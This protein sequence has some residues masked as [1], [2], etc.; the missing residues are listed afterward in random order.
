MTSDCSDIIRKHDPDRFLLSLFVPRA[1]RA[2]LWALFAFNYEIA[3]TREV[4]SDT[5]IGLIRLQWWRD[6]IAEIYAE[7]SK[8]K[9]VRR[10]EVVQP[11]A[12]AIK[13]YDLPREDFEGL[14]YA[15]EFDLEGVA[16][17]NL[18]GLINYCDYTTVPLMRLALKII[19]EEE[20]E[21]V[22]RRV[23]VHYALVG[24][25]RA[26]PYMR[27]QR[28][29]MLPQ[30][31]MSKNNVSEQEFFDFNRFEKLP[32]V[33]IEALGGVKELRNASSVPKTRF[34]KAMLAMTILYEQQVRGASYDVFDPSLRLQPK[35]FALRLWV[36]SFF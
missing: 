35:F 31:I 30:N 28:R 32:D 5:T 25:L 3:K 17:S 4:V 34:L 11:L 15:R 12:E 24:T 8:S 1:A 10:H 19:G 16:P 22:L 18:E 27:E 6:A 29:L 7:D 9:A 23:S 13:T 14:I 26:V 20:E 21:A 2:S 36:K 33:V